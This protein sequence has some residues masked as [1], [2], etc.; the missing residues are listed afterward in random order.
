MLNASGQASAN[1][2]NGTSTPATLP[3]T[4]VNG[5]CVLLEVLRDLDAEVDSKLRR[6]EARLKK[7]R[8]ANVVTPNGRQ[9][10]E[11]ETSRL[12]SMQAKFKEL[13]LQ[14]RD[15]ADLESIDH[16]SSDK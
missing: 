2:A 5:R 8:T 6:L 1:Q 16:A 12:S 15:C 9:L 3:V 7:L 14:I 13:M 11:S 4:E 10:L